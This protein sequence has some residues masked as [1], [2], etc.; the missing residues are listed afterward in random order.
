MK[1][2]CIEEARGTYQRWGTSISTLGCS[3]SIRPS[4]FITIR[5]HSMTAERLHADVKHY[6]LIIITNNPH[7]KPF[8]FARRDQLYL[9][10]ALPTFNPSTRLEIMIYKI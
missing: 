3:S 10:I 8:F 6:F 7:C 9:A 5:C 4:G 1:I 2:V